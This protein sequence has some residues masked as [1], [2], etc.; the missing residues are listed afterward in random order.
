LPVSDLDLTTL[1][2]LLGSTLS[3]E[4]FTQT[5]VGDLAAS[6]GTTAETLATDLGTTT[7]ELPATAMALTTPLSNGNL[8]SLLDG[9][10]GLSL[11]V[12]H[13]GEEGGGGSVGNGG[14]GGAGGSRKGSEGRSG[15]T[16]GN[17]SSSQGSSSG[18]SS[19]GSS[20]PGK[21]P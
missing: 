3:G 21:L 13:I 4:P 5:T 2:G 12:L 7:K 9:L 15:G 8:L 1:K 11:S 18:A 17:G 19:S 10:G 14:V 20:T 16:R 6:L